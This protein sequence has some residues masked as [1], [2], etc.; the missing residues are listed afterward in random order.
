[1]D[2]SI[3]FPV[4]MLDRAVLFPGA[5]V[6][7][8]LP[9]RGAAAAKH[10]KTG[11]LVAVCT[12]RGPMQ[13]LEGFACIA[14]V[15][16][17]AQDAP[18]G[19]AVYVLQGQAR[20][21]LAEVMLSDGFQVVEADPMQDQREDDPLA[22]ALAES[23]RKT[24]LEIV[25]LMKELPREAKGPIEGVKA[26]SALA[27]LLAANVEA[28]LDEKLELL[29]TRDVP[30]RTAHVLALL[31]RQLEILLMRERANVWIRA[32]MQKEARAGHPAL[33]T[34]E[35]KRRYVL[36]LQR[37]YLAT[38]VGAD[39]EQASALQYRGAPSTASLAAAARSLTDPATAKSEP[40]WRSLLQALGVH[41]ESL[42]HLIEERLTVLREKQRKEVQR[43]Q[44]RAIDED[45]A[46]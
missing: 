5:T 24:S 35:E 8:P 6:A 3:T 42:S 23:A 1:M 27:D 32:E 15:R 13:G 17:R 9:G 34:E 19:E 18:S 44:L 38:L 39:E 31:A 30:T 46:R 36:R 2:P 33:Q 25:H 22:F 20:A 45:L 21:M 16:G 43:A 26:P 29:S 10:K 37:R 40:A 7:L 28:E 11:G 14:E 41:R 4:V 12:V